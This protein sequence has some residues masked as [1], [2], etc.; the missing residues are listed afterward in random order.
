MKDAVFWHL[1]H[2][3]DEQLRA[4]L[5]ELLANGYRTEARIIAHLAEV[6]TRKLHLMDGGESL[7]DYCQTRLRLSASEAFH[8]ITAARIAR[9]FPIVFRMIEERK[10]H[11][12]AVCLLR[13]YL[14]QENHH[15]LLQAASGKTKWQVQEL[16]ARR[17][18]RPDV[19]SRI[20]RLPT[21]RASGVG[22]PSRSVPTS[23]NSHA[24]GLSG[25]SERPPCPVEIPIPAAK[26][27]ANAVVEPLSEA[28]YRIQLNATSALREKLERLRALISHANPSGDIAVVIEHALDLALEKVEKRRFARTDKPALARS[29]S[30]QV[31][32][33]RRALRRDAAHE[34]AIVAVERRDHIPNAIRREVAARDGLRCTYRSPDGH[35][36]P[37]R[38]FLQIHEAGGVDADTRGPM[39]IANEEAIGRPAQANPILVMAVSACCP[40]AKP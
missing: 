11:L 23:G 30:L 39:S 17:F 8:R 1:Q 27:S 32:R 10:L 3:S 7:F 20:R 4:G 24:P 22:A 18:P 15:D 13:D 34:G 25:L 9:K 37:G 33:R 26:P 40:V 16:L 12:T 31:K 5:A 29:I 14:T 35:R 6:E 21:P 38:A 28:R 36:C 19:E 2:A